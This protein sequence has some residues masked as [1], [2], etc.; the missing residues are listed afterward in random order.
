MK[1][2]KKNRDR[3]GRGRERD[4]WNQ[5]EVCERWQKLKNNRKAERVKLDSI[6]S[7]DLV[8]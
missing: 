8:T 5:S 3:E 2:G 1:A 6:G 7:C 4:G